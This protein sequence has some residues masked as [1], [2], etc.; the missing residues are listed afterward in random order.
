MRRAEAGTEPREG[1]PY[2]R[3]LAQGKPEPGE[4]T[5]KHPPMDQGHRAKI[6][7]PFDA[8]DGFSELIRQKDRSREEAAREETEEDP[9]V[10]RENP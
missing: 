2:F 8:L 4:G 1:F 9:R 3:V 10:F 7:A 5:T 6:F